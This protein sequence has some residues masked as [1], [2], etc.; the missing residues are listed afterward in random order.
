MS[1]AITIIGRDS[2]HEK[3]LQT[4]IKKTLRGMLDLEITLS[5]QASVLS[6]I[7]RS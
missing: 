1:I 7:L 6:S 4:Q 5:H 3:L 2:K